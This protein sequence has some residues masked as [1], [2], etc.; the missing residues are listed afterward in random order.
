MNYYMTSDRFLD[1][2]VELYPAWSHGGNGRTAYA[3]VEAV[4]A[5]PKGLI[6]HER[7]LLAAW[8]RYGLPVALTEVHLGCTREEQVRWLVAAWEGA[9]RARR[10]GAD[11]RAVTLWSLL[12]SYDWSSL[13]TCDRGDYEPGAFDVRGPSPRPT[14]VAG[15]ARHLAAQDGASHVVLHTPGWW[16]RPERLR[17]GAA[18]A[19]AARSALGGRPILIVGLQGTL[20]RAF[21]QLC[22]G[23]GLHAHAVGRTEMDICE[24]P[25]IDAVLRRLDPWAVINAA[26]YV[27]V[28]A[29]ETDREGCWRDNVHGAVNLAAACRRRGLPLVTFSSDLVFDGALRRP[30][31]EQD[32]PAPLSAYGE[33]KA[34]AERRVLDL[35]SDAL[36]VRTSA[37][38]GPWDDYNFATMAL[39]TVAEGGHVQ[40]PDDYIV[41][42]T[43][44]P[45][46]VHATLD[47]LID[48]ERG[49]WH[50]ANEGAVTWWE[51]ARMVA[52][53]TGAG[54]DAIRGCSWR[55]IW[56]PAKRPSY[57]V[58]GSARGRLMR[59]LE[60]AITAY[61]AEAA[62][63]R[64]EAARC[65]SS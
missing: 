2:R 10:S 15:I 13:V 11:V 58:L 14:A 52:R 25:R 55:E 26:G 31:T 12:G 59:P 46:L 32:E 18:A 44:V 5:H 1:D 60:A 45:D 51:F 64:H 3:D 33:A 16:R 22:A 42:P 29:A 53:A 65:A 23:R 4:R 62:I 48:G 50:L 38:F 37:F 19:A 6:G 7:H 9:R 56:Q 27:R 17:F 49:I 57:S 30:Y 8:T 43:Y 40:A 34:E 39:R 28:D 54:D 20:G 61:A 41:S 35:L 47:L 63:A 21:Q 36:V 24:P